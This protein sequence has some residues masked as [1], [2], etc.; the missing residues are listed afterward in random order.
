MRKPKTQIRKIKA[1]WEQIDEIKRGRRRTPIFK[2]VNGKLVAV[3]VRR[4]KQVYMQGAR[5]IYEAVESGNATWQIDMTLWTELHRREV[6]MFGVYCKDN[7]GLWITK[8]EN[9]SDS[10][11]T[12]KK[13]GEFTDREVLIHLPFRYW[14]YK[15]GLDIPL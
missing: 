4:F 12:M 11:R 1:A 14:N 6:D 10:T 3:Q 7:D 9:F 15:Q 5:S 8:F 13:Q 2:T